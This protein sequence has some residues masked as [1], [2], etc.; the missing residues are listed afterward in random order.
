MRW[1]EARKARLLP[2][3]LAERARVIRPIRKG[4]LL[5]HDNCAIDDSLTIVKLRRELDRADQRFLSADA[6]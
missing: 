4:E 5:S 1:A 2:I 3:G 6:A